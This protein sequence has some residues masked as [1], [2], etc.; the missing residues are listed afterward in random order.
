MR[1]E[2]D[3]GQKP[4]KKKAASALESATEFGFGSVNYTTKFFAF[5]TISQLQCQEGLSTATPFF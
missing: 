4:C 5:N 1:A 2:R 3:R